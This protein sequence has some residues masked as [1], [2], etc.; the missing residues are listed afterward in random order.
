MAHD[1]GK[2]QPPSLEEF[3]KRLDAARGDRVDAE[4]ARA[5]NGKGMGKAFRLS[6]ELLAALIVGVLLG[7]GA[8]RLFG[9]SP[10]GLLAGIFI[11]FAAGVLNVSRAMKEQDD[12]GAADDQAET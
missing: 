11:G 1:A 2:Q 9:I 7:W 6:S 10:W 8:D 3:S 12:A 5:G 4:S